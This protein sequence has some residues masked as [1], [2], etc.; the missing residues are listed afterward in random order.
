MAGVH[1]TTMPCKPNTTKGH[2]ESHIFCEIC[3]CTNNIV[4]ARFEV[5]TTFL[6]V[7]MSVFKIFVRQELWVNVPVAI[8]FGT[9]TCGYFVKVFLRVVSVYILFQIKSLFL[10]YK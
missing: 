1:L 7:L 10:D 9:V 4:R 3:P 8:F 5:F 2:I 6:C